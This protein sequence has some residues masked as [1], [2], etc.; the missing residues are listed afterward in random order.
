MPT[1]LCSLSPLVENS[2]SFTQWS[3]GVHRCFLVSF[4][5]FLEFTNTTPQEKPASPIGVFPCVLRP[6]GEDR[7]SQRS[8]FLWLDRI[9][10]WGCKLVNNPLNPLYLC[11]AFSPSFSIYSP[12]SPGI[13]R[14]DIIKV[15]PPPWSGSFVMIIS[16]RL[17]LREFISF[18]FF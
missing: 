15:P 11:P 13:F 9:S 18:P 12:P 8:S 16:V 4:S 10:F 14:L 7:S 2:L 17:F 3:P 1:A 6:P 5:R